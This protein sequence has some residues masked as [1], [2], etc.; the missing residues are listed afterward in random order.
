MPTTAY[1]SPGTPAGLTASDDTRVR[2]NTGNNTTGTDFGF[3][4]PSGATIDGV[5]ATVEWSVTAGSWTA[6]VGLWDAGAVI[7]TAKTSAAITSTTDVVVNFGGA[8]DLWGATLTQ[9]IVNGAGFGLDVSVVRDSGAGNARFDVDHVQLRI[10]YTESTGQ[11]VTVMI[12][13]DGT[14][15]AK[16]RLVKVGGVFQ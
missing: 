9:A 6:T 3:A 1:L 16:P 13:I 15:V 12:K 7:G 10:T 4:L 8:A 2:L 11:T 14:F 5:E